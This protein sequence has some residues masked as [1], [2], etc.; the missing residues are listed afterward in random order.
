MM[1]Q[2]RIIYQGP[3]SAAVAH[4]NSLGFSFP[5]TTEPGEFLLSVCAHLSRFS[6]ICVQVILLK[7]CLVQV[8]DP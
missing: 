3:V 1:R 5:T 6:H 4:F 7:A 8:H 2:G